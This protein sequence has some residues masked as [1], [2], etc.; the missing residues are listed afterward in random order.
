M[1]EKETNCWKKTV[2]LFACKNISESVRSFISLTEVVVVF[3]KFDF[4]H[5]AMTWSKMSMSNARIES[6]NTFNFMKLWFSTATP[7]K[8]IE[9][10]GIE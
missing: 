1:V 3:T 7:T 6:S 10:V 8:L 2:E 9:F 5:Q 4:V